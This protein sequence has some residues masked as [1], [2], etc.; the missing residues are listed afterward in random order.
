MR[1]TVAINIKTEEIIAILN[2]YRRNPALESFLEQ[3][4]PLIQQWM[5]TQTQ[6]VP[7]PP[8]GMYE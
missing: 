3:F 2:A 7:P 4:M 6:E 5:M 8:K 1:V